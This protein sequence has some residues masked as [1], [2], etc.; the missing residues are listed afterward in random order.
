MNPEE[1]RLRDKAEMCEI[2]HAFWSAKIENALEELEEQGDF[3]TP[4][5]MHSQIEKEDHLKYLLIH[6]AFEQRE[7]DKL[8]REIRKYIDENEA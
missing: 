7:M 1:K 2:S 3:E 4:E 5:E 6:S 8:D